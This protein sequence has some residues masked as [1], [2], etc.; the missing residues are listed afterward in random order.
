MARAMIEN[1]EL[2]LGLFGKTYYLMTYIAD[3]VWMVL[4]HGAMIVNA[5]G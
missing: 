5:G 2:L 1:N 3:R 4:V